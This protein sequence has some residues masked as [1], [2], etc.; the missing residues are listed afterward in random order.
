MNE[1]VREAE[2]SIDAVR[3]ID[4][5]KCPDGFYNKA[6]VFTMDDGRQVIGKVPNPN[7]GIPHYTT[8]SEVATMDFVGLRFQWLYALKLI[9]LLDAQCSWNSSAKGV[10]VELP[11]KW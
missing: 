7:A 1:L 5:K 4:V 2:K 10:C 9:S 11:C 3:C 6:Y 8:A